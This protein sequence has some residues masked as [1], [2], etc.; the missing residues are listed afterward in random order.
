MGK[1]E[2]AHFF[3]ILLC[4]TAVWAC[5]PRTNQRAPNWERVPVSVELRLAQAAQGPGLVPA[6]VYGQG[7]TIYLDPNGLSSSDIARVEAT[8]AMTGTGLVLDV[9]FTKSG[10]R[11]LAELTAHHI[12]DSLAVL[13]DSVV[14]SVPPIQ[15][16]ID[17]GTNLPSSIGVPLGHE[18]ARQLAAA[19]AKT[20]PIDVK[21]R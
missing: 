18:E 21:R 7:Q 17:I 12:G 15:D 11:R 2:G 3:R 10:A 5:S 14:L 1:S 8:K 6:S 16:T 19:V 20:W 13:V 9:W 4:V